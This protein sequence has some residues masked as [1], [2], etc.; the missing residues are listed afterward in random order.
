MNA[1]A[2]DPR[3]CAEMSPL[4]F[5]SIEISPKLDDVVWSENKSPNTPFENTRAE[6]RVPG[7]E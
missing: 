4:G 5:I 2:P 7:R 3:S 1:K 6:P